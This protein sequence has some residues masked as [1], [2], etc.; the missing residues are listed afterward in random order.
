MFIFQDSFNDLMIAAAIVLFALVAKFALPKAQAKSIRSREATILMAI[1]AIIY[2]G[3]FYTLGAIANSFSINVHKFGLETIL[4][5]IIPV[6]ATI[7]ASEFI[8]CRLLPAELNVHIKGRNYNLSTLFV[9]II[10]VLIDALFYI[11]AYDLTSYD[12][13]IVA[14]GF[15]LFASVANTM[16]FNYVANRYGMA[17]NTVFRLITILYG[18]LLPIVPDIYVYLRSFLR[19]VY[20]AIMYLIL[21]HALEPRGEYA[22][23]S[24]SRRRTAII[25]SSI[26][27][28]LTGFTMLVS[29]KFKYGML[30]IATDS[31][32]GTL[33]RGTAVVY[34]QY[35]DQQISKDQ[36]ILFE[37]ADVVVVHRVVKIEQTS[38]GLHYITKGDANEKND[39]GYVTESDLVGVMQFSVENLG[40]PTLW[41]RSLFRA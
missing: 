5:S 19:I 29:C 22:V 8:R 1:F 25:V 18:Y 40:W 16:L 20:P 32:T 34:E 6:A 36:I 11:R 23:A 31:M 4:N 38:E 26:I 21:S 30:V 37:R 2:V 12:Q 35:D 10:M 13:F 7:V 15:V 14:V 9:L 33:N 28:L 41:V 27:L 24:S 17:G 3:G 39:E